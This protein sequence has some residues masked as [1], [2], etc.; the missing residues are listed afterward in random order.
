MRRVRFVVTSLAHAASGAP[1]TWT[2]VALGWILFAVCS[3]SDSLSSLSLGDPM[4]VTDILTSGL[5]FATLPA[6]I[7]ATALA[8]TGAT[9][10]ERKVGSSWSVAV[11]LLI[12]VVGGAPSSRGLS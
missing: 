7:V 1:V 5:T 6:G 10:T 11:I 3:R 2:L 4:N 8:L 9:Y 12:Q